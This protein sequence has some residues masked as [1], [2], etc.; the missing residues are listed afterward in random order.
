[1]YGLMYVRMYG[2]QYICMSVCM[3]GYL[4]VCMQPSIN[5]CMYEDGWMDGWLDRTQH[6]QRI[7]VGYIIGIH[8][9]CSNFE[10]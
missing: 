9:K 1:M 10:N 6:K 3:N 2:W 5:V 8:L 7:I 4:H